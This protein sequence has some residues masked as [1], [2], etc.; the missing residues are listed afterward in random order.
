[1]RNREQL[2][3]ILGKLVNKPETSDGPLEAD[4][5]VPVSKKST[6]CFRSS[7][8]KLDSPESRDQ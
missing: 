1:M 6:H 8:L 2:K 5:P 3:P 7:V 4:A